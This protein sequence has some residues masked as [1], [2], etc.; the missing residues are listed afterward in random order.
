MVTSLAP[1]PWP[2]DARTG[3]QVPGRLASML[4]T[5]RFPQGYFTY[6][7]GGPG[8]RLTPRIKCRSILRDVELLSRAGFHIRPTVTMSGLPCAW[9]CGPPL[10]PLLRMLRHPQDAERTTAYRL[11]LGIPSHRDPVR[12]GTG[13][14]PGAAGGIE[15]SAGQVLSIWDERYRCLAPVFLSCYSFILRLSP[16]EDEDR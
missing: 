12:I 15:A 14:N 2:V 6:S 11:S 16:S 1:G 13:S 10:P 9:I 4:R 7:T 3:W 8:G 5:L